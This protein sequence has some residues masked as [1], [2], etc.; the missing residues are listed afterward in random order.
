MKSCHVM[1]LCN[2][3][4]FLRQ[5]LPFLYENFAQLIFYDL[6]IYMPYLGKPPCFSTDGSHE[7]IKEFPDPEGKIT[8]IEETNLS[9]FPSDVGVGTKDKCRMY[10]AS[11]SY[12]RDD[13]DIV[14]ET[15]ADEFFHKDAIGEAERIFTENPEMISIYLDWYTF[16]RD[17]RF[18]CYPPLNKTPYWDWSFMKRVVR[19]SK[20]RVYAHGDLVPGKSPTCKMENF[21]LYHF[22]ALTKERVLFKHLPPERRVRDGFW[23][24]WDKFDESKV[25]DG[26][27]YGYP[28]MHYSPMLNTGIRRFKGEYPD[29]I[30]LDELPKE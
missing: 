16:V 10:F 13:I 30:K 6:N 19:H 9:R 5:K 22:T 21:K 25:G 20:G 17:Y 23:E 8:L 24:A 11:S 3:I 2:E 15:D 1:H 28:Y 14:W 18:V 4:S 26:Y 12:V 29:Y 7:Y 27:I